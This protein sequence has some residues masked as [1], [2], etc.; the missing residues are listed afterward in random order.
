MYVY[1]NNLQLTYTVIINII[2]AHVVTGHEEMFKLLVQNV[3]I[4]KFRVV[5]RVCNGINRDCR[6]AQAR[7]EVQARTQR[8]THAGAQE[9]TRWHSHMSRHTC[10]RRYVCTHK[11]A[12]MCSRA[13]MIYSSG[14][15]S[16]SKATTL[17]L[18]SFSN[19][20]CI[21]LFLLLL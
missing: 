7:T 20:L 14:P 1:W 10:K 12:H 15:L 9:C 21:Y 16:I 2:T 4:M 18:G 13:H 19:Q 17:Y 8:H 3:N 5:M 11:S 6:G